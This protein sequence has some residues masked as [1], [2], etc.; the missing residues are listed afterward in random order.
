MKGMNS[1]P[2]PEEE[3]L[4]Q[5]L[6][7]LE[8]FAGPTALLDAQARVLA[9][10]AEAQ[11]LL[12]GR[13]S[14]GQRFQEAF[15][16]EAEEELR[17]AL[18]SQRELVLTP[19]GPEARRRPRALRLRATALAEGGRGTGWAVLL[20]PCQVD[21][22]SR[23]ELF[24]GLWT[25]DPRMRRLFRIIEKAA[26]TEASVLVRGESGTGKELVANALH[27]L[28]PRSRGPF[29]AINCA[30]LSPSLLESEL[31]GHVRGAFTGAVRDSPGHFRLAQGGTLF[32]DEVAELPLEL[33][34][35]L[36][37]VLETRTVI[38]VGGRESVAVDVRI[39]AATHRALRREVEQG[40][41]RADLMYRLRVVPIFLPALRERPGDILP[42]A[43]RFLAELN[44][45][46][47][48]QVLRISARARRQLQEYPWP[49]NVRELRNVMEY[50]H[51]MGEGPTLTEAELPP[52]FNEQARPVRLPLAP[53]SIAAPPP[54]ATPARELRLE[55]LRR[56]LEKTGG[57][58]ARAASLL[59]ISRVTLW[60]RLREAGE[61]N[62]G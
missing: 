14:L 56:A 38:P 7:A 3:T 21:P 46:G 37:R 31:F 44:A 54:T 60:R 23:E 57:N 52:E 43:E 17:A 62:A 41:F 48:R 47:G 2:P 40:R 55:D 10:G 28:S 19:G 50:A 24:H 6:R 45:R 16:K 61:A 35:K 39:V 11:E 1:G 34:A 13:V 49:G 32:L 42:L 30:A 26:R 51:V 25:Q 53:E 5:A 8:T 36:L 12:E 29:R 27:V 59:G 18:R 33:Q 22:S 15:P 9:L 4:R 20:A 58:R